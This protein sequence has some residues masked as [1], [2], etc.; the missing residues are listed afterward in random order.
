MDEHIRLR[1][2]RWASELKS[3]QS[4]SDIFKVQT[5]INVRH[6]HAREA[7]RGMNDF[8][9]SIGAEAGRS[10]NDEGVPF[11]VIDKAVNG[12]RQTTW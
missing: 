9:P 6:F 12:G 1:L 10:D 5:Q 4:E 8:M 2:D 3:T 7:W 11:T